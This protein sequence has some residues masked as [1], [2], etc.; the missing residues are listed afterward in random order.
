MIGK[1]VS[2]DNTNR[3]KIEIDPLVGEIVSDPDCPVDAKLIVGLAGDSGKPNR[4]RLYLTLEFDNYVE[5]ELEDVVSS[6]KIRN[7]ESEIQVTAIWLN[8]NA[9]IQQSKVRTR[10]VQARFLTGSVASKYA[11]RQSAGR[12]PFGG[13]QVLGPLS[14]LCDGTLG[15]FLGGGGGCAQVGGYS[16]A[17]SCV[18]EFCEFVA[19]T[20][21]P[22]EVACTWE[23][24]C[25]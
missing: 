11:G 23:A 1:D 2:K 10:E 9:K 5:F 15:S 20:W 7:D 18:R 6:K 4:C 13:P 12:N 24:E 17:L 19:A 16:Q 25:P 3:A 14:I 8:R 22:D 21:L